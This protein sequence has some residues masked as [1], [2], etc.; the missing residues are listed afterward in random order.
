MSFGLGSFGGFLDAAMSIP[1]QMWNEE[2]QEDAQVHATR[3]MGYAQT[4]NS[5][6]AAANRDWM[7]EMSDT[8]HQRSVKDLRLAGL[9]PILAARQGAST[10][11][12]GAASSSAA[13]GSGGQGATVKS[14]FAMLDNIR[15]DTIKKTQE[16]YGVSANT[17]RTEHE[18]DLLR[19]KVKTEAELTKQA[20][21]MAETA[22]ASAQGAANEG[23][24]DKTT[25]GQFLRW[26]NRISESLQG[27]SSAAKRAKPH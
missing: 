26:I 14:Q 20:K 15:S 11:G 2:M 13:T 16:A 10:P 21:A 23:E 17:V 19:Q 18:T 27:A 25:A 3:N 12:G 6:E 9:N 4:F 1:Q 8:S 7:K 24:I 5:A 22:A